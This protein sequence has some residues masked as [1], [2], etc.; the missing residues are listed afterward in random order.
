MCVKEINRYVMCGCQ[1]TVIHIRTC[2]DK[3]LKDE[4]GGIYGYASCPDSEMGHET[5]DPHM[6]GWCPRCALNNLVVFGDKLVP[7]SIS[8][9]KMVP[10]TLLPRK[11]KA[12]KGKHGQVSQYC[13]FRSKIANNSVQCR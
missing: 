6:S 13:F 7:K 8:E 1:D 3:L 9:T 11:V 2:T 4:F 10:V 12:E 5:R